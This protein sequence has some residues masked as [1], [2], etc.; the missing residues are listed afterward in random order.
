MAAASREVEQLL[1]RIGN[2]VRRRD[3]LR[4]VGVERHEL[5]TFDTEIER[6]RWRLAGAA[7][8]RAVEGGEAA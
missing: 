8:A 3:F 4:R 7:R 5:R 2:L 6:L 1:E